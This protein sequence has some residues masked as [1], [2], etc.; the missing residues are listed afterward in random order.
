MVVGLTGLALLQTGVIYPPASIGPVNL[1]EVK[2][3]EPPPLSGQ[4][5]SAQGGQQAPSE[6]LGTPK[7]ATAPQVGKGE[8]RNQGQAQV[9]QPRTTPGSAEI[10]RQRRQ[11]HSKSESERYAQKVP[12]AQT[13][14]PV[15][16]RFNFDPARNRRLDVAQVHLGD[17]IR[18][19]VRQV[20]QVGRRVYFTYSRSLNSP[21]GA[22]LK[23]ETMYSFERR[24]IS[25]RDSGYYVIEVK[26]Y[27]GNR[28]NTKPRSFV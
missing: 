9:E 25:G 21:Q 16:I 10:D 28:W 13:T 8:R 23:L 2:S 4:G 7:T 17:K 20:G 22:V 27:P 1:P 26:I 18:V 11:A 14:K 3:P 19:K 6:D 15:V 24:V 5:P 12:P